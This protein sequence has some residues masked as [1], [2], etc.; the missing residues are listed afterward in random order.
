M[1]DKRAKPAKAI[2]TVTNQVSEVDRE[3]G[4]II[5]STEQKHV[6]AKQEFSGVL[7]FTKMFYT[8]L[9]RI[10]GLSKGAMMVF[11][12]LGGMMRDNDN[13]IVLTAI[14]REEISS[15]TGLKKQAIY[16]ATRELVASGLLKRVVS[17]VYMVDPS[18]FAVGND[19][20]V[21]SNR[22]EFAKLKAIDMKVR[23]TEEG[24]QISVSVEQGTSC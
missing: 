3:T 10:Y 15:R 24:R 22:K 5:T 18:I 2:F 6:I 17:S 11:I 8:D 4:E 12:E 21:M 20:K 16:N 14:E 13:H 19:V 9:F 1:K 23:Y 7:T